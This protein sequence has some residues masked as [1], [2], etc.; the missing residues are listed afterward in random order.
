[1]GKD[2]DKEFL[3]K[4]NILYVEDEKEIREQLSKL[5]ARR[6]NELYTAENGEIGLKLFKEQK[7]DVVITDIQM[8]IMD[9][10]EMAEEI[11]NINADVPIIVITAFNE[12]DYLLKSIDLA[13]SKYLFKPII[14]T[15]LIEVIYE[16]SKKYVESRS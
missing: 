4:L 2:V 10:L 7:V 8:P 3:K 9:G 6:I 5:L 13:I 14:P 16:K 12:S 11:R 1:M 15:T